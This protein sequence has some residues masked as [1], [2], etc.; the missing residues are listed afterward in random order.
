MADTLIVR[1]N[2]LNAFGNILG[3]D[4]RVLEMFDFSNVLKRIFVELFLILHVKIPAWCYNDELI[5]VDE[6]TVIVFDGHAR[7]E[8]LEWLKSYNPDKRLIFWCWN[9]I[10]EIEKNLQMESIP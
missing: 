4:I 5:D 2:R 1:S 7:V 3:N 6:G 9:T 8:F 10:D